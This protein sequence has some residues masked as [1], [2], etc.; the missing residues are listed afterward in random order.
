MTLR[1]HWRSTVTSIWC[2]R[3]LFALTLLSLLHLY[4]CIVVQKPPRRWLTPARL[5]S[6][7]GL[8]HGEGASRAGAAAVTPDWGGSEKWTHFH[9]CAWHIHGEQTLLAGYMFVSFYWWTLKSNGFLFPMQSEAAVLLYTLLRQLH[10]VFFQWDCFFM[11]GIDLLVSLDFCVARQTTR[12]WSYSRTHGPLQRRSKL[13][14]ELMKKN[15]RM[16]WGRHRKFKRY[17][18][19]CLLCLPSSC[20]IFSAAPIDTSM[21][22][23]FLAFCPVL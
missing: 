11:C 12:C 15:L 4:C 10:L 7:A 20:K 1:K 2:I 22:F 17:Q 19:C 23:L 16:L 21:D 9:V 8:F 18:C 5:N 14:C 6:E 13:I 3:E